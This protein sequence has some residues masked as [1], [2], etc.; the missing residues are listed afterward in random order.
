MRGGAV[1]VGGAVLCS[2]EGGAS[3]PG[4]Q[5]LGVRLVRWVIG[6][7]DGLQKSVGVSGQQVEFSRR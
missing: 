3:A 6:R 5:N 7:C 4:E 2:G 1:V